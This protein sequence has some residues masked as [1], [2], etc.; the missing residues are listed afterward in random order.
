MAAVSVII[1]SYNHSVFLKD[2]LNSILNQTFKDWEAIIIDDKSTDNSVSVIEEFLRSNPGFKVNQFIVNNENS[3]SGYYSWQKGIELAETKYIWIAETDDYSE[4]TFLEEL[5]EILDHNNDVAIAFCGSNYV[6][7]GK[8]IY[9]STNRMRDLKV[10]IGNYKVLNNKFFLDQLPFNTYI[11]NGS[12][13]L[14]RKPELEIPQQIFTNR[15]CS[16]IFLWSYLLQNRPFVYLNKNLNFFRR[17]QSSTTTIL[18]K[19]NLEL[20]YHEKAKFLN[21]FGKTDKYKQF[22]DHYIQ[23][24]IWNN[25]KDFLNTSSIKRIQ[26]EKNLKMIYFYRLIKF[27]FHKIFNRIIKIKKQ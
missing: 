20:I 15:Q 26:K 16:D 27:S 17:H 6:E 25:K 13:A 3:G 18:Y 8:I 24:Y 19:D 9:D 7:E 10:E 14:F 12:S 1:P 4:L 21:Y 5:V 22:I 23:H 2:R 11:T